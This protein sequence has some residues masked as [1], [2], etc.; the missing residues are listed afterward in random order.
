[1]N[2]SSTRG[3]ADTQP[4][5][6]VRMDPNHPILTPTPSLPSLDICAS[7]ESPNLKPASRRRGGPFLVS[8]DSAVPQTPPRV[9]G[10][11]A[12]TPLLLPPA[13]ASAAG[14]ARRAS[15]D[16]ISVVSPARAPTRKCGD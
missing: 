11:A 14:L 4:S 7:T 15:P 5:D 9:G 16:C 12:A 6:T 13:P 1:M 10:S 3:D 2:A 8:G